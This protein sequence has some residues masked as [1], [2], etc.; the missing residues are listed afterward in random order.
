M[1]LQKPGGFAQSV[2]TDLAQANTQ[3]KSVITWYKPSER[4]PPDNRH[5]LI[6]V[7][8]KAYR[9]INR[10]DSWRIDANLTLHRDP[11]WWAELPKVPGGVE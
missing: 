7:N 9:A 10:Y 1:N 2:A 8:D 4:M 6:A 3:P 11:D 5:I